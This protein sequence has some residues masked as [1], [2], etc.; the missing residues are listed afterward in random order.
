MSGMEIFK[1][2][3]QALR[4]DVVESFSV[5]AESSKAEVTKFMAQYKARGAH[6]LIGAYVVGYGDMIKTTI[7]EL[8]TQGFDGP[9]AC[10]STLTDSEWQPIERTADQRIF[11]VLPR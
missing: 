10:T 3:F 9:I 4:G 5:T 11:T 1:N 8:V 7:G 2:R 6:S